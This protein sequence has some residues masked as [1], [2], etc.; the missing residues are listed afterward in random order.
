[1]NS[2]FGLQRIARPS[3]LG[4]V[5]AFLFRSIALVSAIANPKH[6][7]KLNDAMRRRLEVLELQMA[8]LGNTT[9]PHIVTEAE[10]LRA[11]LAGEAL[12]EP[13]SDEERYRSVMRAVMILSEQ[14][15]ACQVRVERLHWLLPT[16]LFAYLILE[17]IVRHL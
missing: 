16:M 8:Q 15:S 11:K 14:V 17:W 13:I 9:P 7:Q 10:D 6:A 3:A 5:A 12:A 1:L 2:E 4:L